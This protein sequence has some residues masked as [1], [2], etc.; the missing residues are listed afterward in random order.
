M[1]RCCKIILGLAISIIIIAVLILYF[2]PA[3]KILVYSVPICGTLMEKP[4]DAL[5]KKDFYLFRVTRFSPQTAEVIAVNDTRCETEYMANVA[6]VLSD[7]KK[8]MFGIFHIHFTRQEIFL[9]SSPI[10]PWKKYQ[11]RNDP[12]ID[13]LWQDFIKTVYPT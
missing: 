5:I 6:I 12:K 10:F 3:N 7:G 13:A 4:I 9:S 8:V 2:R 11:D 1:G